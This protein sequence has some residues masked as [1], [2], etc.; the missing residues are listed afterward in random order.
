MASMLDP[1]VHANHLTTITLYVHVC[2]RAPRFVSRMQPHLLQ[3]GH[4]GR[5][6]V[7]QDRLRDCQGH[8]LHT[9]RPQHPEHGERNMRGSYD[10]LLS[11]S[12][13]GCLHV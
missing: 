4:C 5:A 1:Q 12:I 9:L 11:V 7:R 2:R 6:V 8:E 13:A 3:G 10:I